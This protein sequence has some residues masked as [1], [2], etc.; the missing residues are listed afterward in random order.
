MQ[1]EIRQNLCLCIA[2][3]G[4]ISEVDVQ[5]LKDLG[6]QS[7]WKNGGMGEEFDNGELPPKHDGH[8][9]DTNGKFLGWVRVVFKVQE[10][11]L[12]TKPIGAAKG[13]LNIYRQTKVILKGDVNGKPSVFGFGWFRDKEG[14]S[15]SSKSPN[16]LNMQVAWC[17]QDK[18]DKWVFPSKTVTYY[19]ML[20]RL[21]SASDILPLIL[22]LEIQDRFVPCDK[23]DIVYKASLKTEWDDQILEI[24]SIKL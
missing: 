16:I 24:S 15:C 10:A 18:G 13:D 1:E 23:G 2:K 19:I 20:R 22:T 8:V 9:V 4:G 3:T 11:I 5:T 21:T 6:F 12:N 17:P 7:P 14:V